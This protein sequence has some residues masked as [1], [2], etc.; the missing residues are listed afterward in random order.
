MF[1]DVDTNRN[2]KFSDVCSDAYTE[3]L[4]PYHT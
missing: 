3:S 1:V 2:K 4:A